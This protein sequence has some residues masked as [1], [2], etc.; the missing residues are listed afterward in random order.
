MMIRL[1]KRPIGPLEINIGN[2]TSSTRCKLTP[3]EGVTDT[4]DA[5]DRI[6]VEGTMMR[7]ASHHRGRPRL[8]L[9][10]AALSISKIQNRAQRLMGILTSHTYFL[11]CKCAA[12]VSRAHS[13]HDET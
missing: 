9:N 4:R 3:A 10:E 8:D 6:A 11:M 13:V 7:L 12:Y 1:R 5:E 2:C